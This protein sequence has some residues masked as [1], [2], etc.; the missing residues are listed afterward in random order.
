M[1]SFVVVA[2]NEA[3]TVGPVVAQAL[4]AADQADSVLVVDSASSDRTPA[5]AREAGAQVIRGPIGKGAAMA[6]AVAVITTDWVCFLDAD[7]TYSEYNIPALL[8]DAA[9]RRLGEHIVGDFDDG[10][11]AVLTNTHGFYAPLVAAL[12]PE[13]VNSFGSKPLTGFRILRREYLRD[14]LPPDF[15]VEAHLNIAVTLAGGA[16]AVI[17][18][19]RF[20]GKLKSNRVR[21]LEITRTILDLAVRY[22]RLSCSQRPEWEAWVQSVYVIAKAW[23]AGGD[24]QDYR[25]RLLGAAGRPLPAPQ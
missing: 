22:D 4:S 12:F 20:D 10:L 9:R 19:G 13:V 11:Q 16:P 2:H 1:I 7:L 18:L 21:S 24:Q 25:A 6:A 8:A 23:Q 5:V 15:G 3:S 17:Q 14:S